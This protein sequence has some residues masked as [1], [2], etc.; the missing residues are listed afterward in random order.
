MQLAAARLAYL[1]SSCYTRRIINS[2]GEDC[3]TIT[4]L[5]LHPVWTVRHL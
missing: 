1:V 5:L 4:R 3:M 2:T